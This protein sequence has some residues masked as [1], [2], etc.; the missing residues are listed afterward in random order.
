MSSGRPV[1]FIPYTGSFPDV[2]ERSIVA[3]DESC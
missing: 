2:G 3:W 1:L